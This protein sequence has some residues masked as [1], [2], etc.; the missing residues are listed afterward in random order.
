MK[1]YYETE[2]LTEALNLMR[3]VDDGKHG[4]MLV[5]NIYKSDYDSNCIVIKYK[6]A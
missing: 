1:A 4:I 2:T 5:Q 6:R 3:Q